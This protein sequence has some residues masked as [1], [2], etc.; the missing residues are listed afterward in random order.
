MLNDARI[1]AI[2]PVSDIDAAIDFYEGRLALRLE[3]RRGIPSL[4][5]AELSGGAGTLLLYE[6]VGAGKSRHTVAAF[7]VDDIDAAVASLRE[8]GVVFEEYDLPE[9][10]TEGGIATLGDARVAWC[11]D[12]DGNILA[13]ESEA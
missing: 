10:R 1:T 7:R 2:V 6:S 11:K 13:I 4:R 12:P 3:R 9:V 5:E 8:R